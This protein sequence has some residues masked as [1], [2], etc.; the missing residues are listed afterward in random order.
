[1]NASDIIAAGAGADGIRAVGSVASRLLRAN[2]NIASLRTNST[3]RQREWIQY[4]TAVIKVAKE[5][6]G[7]LKD[8]MDRGLTHSLP[9]PMAIT[10]VEW[11]QI[12]DVEPAEVT[13][14]ASADTQKDR[15]VYT[16]KGIPIPVIHKDFSIDIRALEASR[17]LGT[18]LDTSAAELMTRRVME[19]AEDMIV[20][21]VSNLTFAGATLQGY[22]TATNR[23]TGSIVNWDTDAGDTAIIPAII[24]MI[25]ALQNDNMYGP[26]MLYVPWTALNH[27]RD[28]Y[29]SFGDKTIM[30][31]I[32][33]IDGI[34]GVR[35]T[36]RLS[37]GASSEALL[38]QM[39][40]DVVDLIDGLQPTIVEWDEMGGLKMNFKILA[41]LAPRVKDDAAGQSGIAHF[42]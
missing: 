29:K 26:Y 35:G 13:M 5:R 7:L 11:E 23:N 17:Q 28:D 34:L 1:M 42:S 18:P 22:K 41:I 19:A 15:P 39:T 40:S 37:G 2:M 3:L 36:S 12:S 25:S 6:L 31:R 8:L 32:M 24:N 4:D 14:T 30:Q 20:N 27:F 38:V 33:E 21:G 9:N 16:L 10:R